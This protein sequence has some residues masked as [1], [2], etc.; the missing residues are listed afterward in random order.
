[1]KKI[2]SIL[3]VAVMSVAVLCCS[4]SAALVEDYTTINGSL[5]LTDDEA[6]AA[7]KYLEVDRD[8]YSPSDFD[9]HYYIEYRSENSDVIVFHDKD[10]VLGKNTP[11]FYVTKSAGTE[12]NDP[13]YYVTYMDMP[14]E[15][16][17]CYVVK[18]SQVFTSSDSGTSPELGEI[19]ADTTTATKGM[20]Q[21]G[22]S[23]FNF[24]LGSSICFLF[25]GVGFVSV[26][27]VLVKKGLKISKR[28]K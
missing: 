18:H 23:A 7:A 3:L 11:A 20:F 14:L 9:K 10:S 5:S 6:I 8:G 27:L 4:A 2:L 17:D 1:M 12:E 16:E 22:G 13:L 15:T 24:L 21:L 25:L 19:I 28:G 26:A